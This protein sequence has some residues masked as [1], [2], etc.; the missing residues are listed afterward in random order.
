MKKPSWTLTAFWRLLA[1]GA[2]FD[3]IRPKAVF[4]SNRPF[5]GDAVLAA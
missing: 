4:R 3:S 1:D 2:S 5:E